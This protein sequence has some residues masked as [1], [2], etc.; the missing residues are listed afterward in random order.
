MKNTGLSLILSGALS[1]ATIVASCA[2]P[3]P[4]AVEAQKECITCHGS[5]GV[6]PYPGWH[7]K[8]EYKNDDCSHC[9]DQK[10][11]NRNLAGDATK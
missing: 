10:T 4:H 9:H 7:A 8:R 3:I 1:L 2:P 5:D 6:K 11:E